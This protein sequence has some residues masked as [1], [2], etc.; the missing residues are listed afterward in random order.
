M[1]G[2][3]LATSRRVRSSE[4]LAFGM[5]T[6]KG[7]RETPEGG[8]PKGNDI[9]NMCL[10]RSMEVGGHFILSHPVSS[11]AGSISVRVGSTTLTNLRI[12]FRRCRTLLGVDVTTILKA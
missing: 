9:P 4:I 3:N 6:L 1:C 12:S 5:E 7:V 2:A 10:L 8:V 11:C